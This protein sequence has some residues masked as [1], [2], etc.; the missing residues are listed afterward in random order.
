[1]LAHGGG[2]MNVARSVY[3][4]MHKWSSICV[5]RDLTCQKRPNMRMQVVLYLCAC[6]WGGGPM[7]QKRR[8]DVPKETYDSV[9]RD[10]SCGPLSVC[11]R[12][13]GDT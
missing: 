10:Q 4:R 1:V 2:H 8:L 9:K 5:K 12:M 7:C 11:M 6:A 13:G 3:M